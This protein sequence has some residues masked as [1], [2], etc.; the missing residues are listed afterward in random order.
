MAIAEYA[1]FDGLGLAELVRNKDVKPI[2]L[3][4][5][6]IG[7]AEAL[8]PKI[9]FVVFRD[10]DRAR[11]AAKGDLPKGPFTGV[12]FFLKDIYANG[13]GHADASGGAL[14]AGR[15]V[16]ERLPAGRTLQAG[17]PR[18]ARQDERAG[19]RSCAD[20]GVEALRPRAQ[21]VES[22]TFDGR[23][24]RRFGGGGRGARRSPCPRQ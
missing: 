3:V 19:I 4:E 9:N 13:P 8:N 5:E 1:D 11:E 15:A 6:A 23:I 2:E 10:Y 7:R 14:H 21:S 18:H 16:A 12:P 22:R 17:G 20:D 24:V